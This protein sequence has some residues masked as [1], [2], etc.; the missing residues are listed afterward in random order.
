[1]FARVTRWP[2]RYSLVFMLALISF[3]SLYFEMIIIRWLASDIRIFAYFKNLPLLAAFLGLGLGCLRARRRP[4]VLFAALCLVLA[5]IVVLAHWLGLVHIRIPEQGDFAFRNDGSIREVGQPPALLLA[6]FVVAVLGLLLLVVEL[7]AVLGERLGTLFDALPPTRAYTVNLVA[8]LVGIWAFAA[9]SWLGWSPAGW[10]A[11]GF[12]ALLPFAGRHPLSLGLLAA[13]VMLITLAP[14]A[15][16]W[17]PYQR[18]DME[19]YL[20][21]DATGQLD[22]AGY[23]LH[24][25]HDVMETGLNLSPEFVQNHPDPGLETWQFVY[26]LPYRFAHPRQV[27]VVGAGMGNDVAAALRHGAETVDAVEIDPTILELGQALHPERPYSSPRVHLIIDDARSVFARSD[28]RYDMVVFGLLDSHTLLSSMSSLRL[29]NYVYTLQSL[30]QARALLAPG[31]Y[32][33]LMISILPLSSGN[34]VWIAARLHQMVTTV[35]GESPVALEYPDRFTLLYMIGPG[36]REQ[37]AADPSLA[38]LVVDSALLGTPVSPTTDDWPFIYLREPSVPLY[39]Y[40]GLLV[41]LLIAGG[42][43]VLLALRNLPPP[44]GAVGRALDAPMFFLGAG[45]MLVE[46]KSISQISLLFGSTWIVNAFSIS[47]ILLLALLANLYVTRWRPTRCGP[48]YALMGLALLVD[49][50]VPLG[51]LGGQNLAVKTALGSLLPVLPLF[52]A[53]TIFSMLLV[54][55]PSPRLAFGSNLLG[56]L[57]G[58][59]LEYTS[60][61]T[62]FKALGLVALALY[63]ASWLALRRRP[64]LGPP[65]QPAYQQIQA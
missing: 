34:T 16:R 9:I 38:A 30:E 8:S 14:G 18:I 41:L 39:P 59:L 57:A 3:A 56:A 63:A 53:G 24:V 26:D 6:K 40:V 28:T 50:A 29:D 20:A 35:F 33:A 27:L 1:M 36:V 42:G 52:F 45:F 22:H 11:L 2:P 62:G 61:A 12:V 21:P 46:V 43:L 65:P 37:V 51:A 64:V 47:A 5:S 54:R 23:T 60:M 49:Y 44:S 17:S 31:G 55:A 15:N 25:N 58:G 13:T 4:F 10:F 19:R 48:A 7:F 32:L